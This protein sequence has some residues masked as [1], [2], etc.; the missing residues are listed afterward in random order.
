MAHGSRRLQHHSGDELHSF[1][2]S[3]LQACTL[4]AGTCC[5]VLDEKLNS[6]YCLM[7][8][9]QHAAQ[10]SPDGGVIAVS[11]SSSGS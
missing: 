1:L 5:L 11:L 6:S 3:I 8:Q 7:L 4:C 2:L 10:R 9:H